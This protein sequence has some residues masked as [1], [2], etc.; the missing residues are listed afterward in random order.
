VK[1]RGFE[2]VSFNRII[3]AGG[4]IYRTVD[5]RL[6]VALVSKRGVWYLPKGLI[7]QGESAEGAAIREVREE[8]G[9]DGK[10]VGKIGEI[11]YGFSGGS[12]Y[13]RK[14][15]H[16]YLLSYVGGSVDAH[17]LEG[18]RVKWFSMLDAVKVLTYINEKKIM[19]KAVEMLKS[20][21][22]GFG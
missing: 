9:L 1:K 13:L 18:D 14:T 3:S 10:L 6:E 11:N 21:S 12:R 17:D 7:E 20:E 16:F 4:V 15:V 19:S 22:K 8:T 5:G 2:E